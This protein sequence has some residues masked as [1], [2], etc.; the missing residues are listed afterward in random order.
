V[1]RRLKNSFALLAVALFSP[2]LFAPRV[3]AD[4]GTEF[5]ESK[6]RPLLADHC[7]KCHSHDAEK[8]KGGLLLDTKDDLLKGGDSGPA[9]VP[10]D[11]EK[12]LLIKAVRYTDDDL[13]MPPK[14]KKLSPEQIANLEAWVKMGAPDPRT[15]QIQK[16]KLKSKNSENHWAFQPIKNSPVPEVKNKSWAKTPID[17]FILAKLEGKKLKPSPAADKRTL[18]RRATFD[19]TGLPPT[20]AEVDNFLNDKSAD[21][22]AKV[23]DRLLASPRYGERWG[24][25]WLDVARYADTRGYVFEGER[26]FPYSYTYRDYV[27]H[28][29][30]EDL[31]YD[32]FILQ[33]IAADKL[34]LG[35]D[36]RP[37]AALGFLTLNRFFLGN[38][39]D[40]I[41]DRIDV[42]TR[43]TMALTVACARCHDH[44][45]DPIPTKDYYSLYGI[46]AS[47]H[48]PKDEPLLGIPAPKELQE[49]YE[50]EKKKRDDAV[51]SF[52]D[53]KTTEMYSQLRNRSGEYLLAA[54]DTS[55]LSDKSKAEN[56][57]R[58]RKL[59]PGVVQRWNES[60]A[61]WSNSTNAIFAPWFSFAS[62]SETNFTTG[63]KPVA[64]KISS[65]KFIN[66]IVVSAFTNA[67]ASMKEVSERYGKIFADT[68]KLW[69]DALTEQAKLT[70]A[71]ALTSLADTNREALRQILY[72]SDAPPNLDNV[73]KLFDIPTSQKLRALQRESDEL[74]ATDPGAPPRAMALLDNDKPENA[75]VLIRGN[76]STRGTEV[77]RHFLT[78]LSG[79][80]PQAF[81]NGSGRLELAQAIVNKMNPLT[82]RVIV[83]RVWLYHFGKGL[84]STPSDFGMRSDP[85]THPELLDYLAWHFMENGWSL[86]KLHREIMLSSVY[87]QSS[88]D[89]PRSEKIDSENKLLWK[90]NR[91]RLDFEELRDS[92]LAT[93]GQLE[94]IN[95]GHPVDIVNPPFAKCRSV[96]G[97]I[98]RQNLPGLFRTFDFPNPDSS[99]AQRFFTTVPQ[100][101]LYLLN[102][103]FVVQQAKSLSDS[104]TF[105]KLPNNEQRIEYLYEQL[106][107]REPARAEMNAAEKFLKIQSTLGTN[108]ISK[109]IW[110]YGYGEFDE[111]KKLVKFSSFKHF[112]DHQW[113]AGEK[114]PDPKF[115]YV[116]LSATGGHP[117]NSHSHAAIRRWIS[118]FDGTVKIEGTLQHSA[119]KGD[120][121]EG[122]IVSSRRGELAKCTAQHGKAETVVKTCEVRRGDTIDFIL[123]MR[124]SPDYDS[125]QWPPKIKVVTVKNG[126]AQT[127]TEWSAQSDFSGPKKT[128]KPLTPW[129][130][131]A[132]VLLLSN[133]FMFVD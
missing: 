55:H 73:E 13:Q 2:A 74:D 8:I 133:E 45:Y 112:D 92:L 48:E 60:L 89:N 11:V 63:A 104:S 97:Y 34:N 52:R 38:I 23:V 7:Y 35:D 20:P 16:A 99:S 15:T 39:H 49:K 14:G 58:E 62:L 118:P 132:Q 66:P 75:H 40:I 113:H 4:A 129:E 87:Q 25:H 107:Q 103:S 51:K 117:G 21:A 47:S 31:P 5:F 88:D 127:Q 22:F 53:E 1:K 114:F 116:M 29:F 119:E 6:I 72:A 19:L 126:N 37:L 12:S 81:T 93:S 57:A 102:N 79:G 90:M 128:F 68:E 109:P 18:I 110:E 65:Q 59:D 96:Y 121:V 44:K 130:K 33:Q 91:Q 10:G 17:N 26:R 106:F 108:E 77:S 71:P 41:D 56:L 111:A 82:A 100:Q 131:Y 78:V 3:F 27:I 105:Q 85:P 84:V 120:G 36:K 43:G 80:N 46:F 42:V 54:F 76:A 83:N 101:A 64:E 30:N 98:D 9:I 124:G 28:A 115:G 69:R 61:K 122:R 123:D 67:P 70:N 86:K 24:R 32:K 94:I 50:K 125:F 95:G